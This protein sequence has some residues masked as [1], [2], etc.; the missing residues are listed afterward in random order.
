MASSWLKDWVATEC[1]VQVRHVFRV[2]RQ[3]RSVSTFRKTL[4]AGLGALQHSRYAWRGPVLLHRDPVRR[5]LV[6][7]RPL[8]VGV[9][10]ALNRAFDMV[11]A[12]AAL[13][14]TAPMMGLAAL[15][16]LFERKGPILYAHPRI[17]RG[18]QVFSVLKFRSMCV[19]GD[20]VVAEH[21]ATNAEARAE[22]EKDHK[23]RNDPRV[24]GLGRV[25]RKSSIDELP[26]IF[27]VIRGEMSIV[28]PRPITQNEIE[29]YGQLF[30][31]YCSVKPGIT[32]VW[33]VSGRNDISYQRRVEMDA[34]YARKKS[35]ILDL[36]LIIA[37]V[38]ALL[39]R[40]GSY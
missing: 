39:S 34:I 11:I 10:G 17:G 5:A 28:G 25:L 18:G 36:R 6:E 8:K 30:E 20:R 35:I 16:I 1:A 24:S 15:L 22:W 37:T 40:R 14:V 29:K 4:A 7:S 2:A 19:D 38:P 9:S 13:I 26:Q 32:G 27:N 3:R 31:C 21:L 12:L 33:Q 23:L